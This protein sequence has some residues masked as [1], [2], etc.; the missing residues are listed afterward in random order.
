[1]VWIEH[2]QTDIDHHK[3]TFH[4]NKID[5]YYLFEH[6]IDHVNRN[7]YHQTDMNSRENI[8]RKNKTTIKNERLFETNRHS[9]R[10]CLFEL[11][12]EAINEDYSITHNFDCMF[13]PLSYFPNDLLEGRSNE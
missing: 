2:D 12:D 4:V 9:S 7:I 11:T 1:M 13:F 6:W 5:R 10:G 8:W 3:C